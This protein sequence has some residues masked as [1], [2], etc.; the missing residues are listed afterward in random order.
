MHL[1]M[2]EPTKIAHQIE[3]MEQLYDP[4]VMFASSKA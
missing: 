3:E 2:P 1:E 4:N